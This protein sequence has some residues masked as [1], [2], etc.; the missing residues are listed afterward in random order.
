MKVFKVG[1]IVL[2]EKIDGEKWIFS[3]TEV[4]H[5]SKEEY[6]ANE[7]YNDTLGNYEP[8]K[9]KPT[10]SSVIITATN[11]S[12][13]FV[14]LRWSSGINKIFPHL[15]KKGWSKGLFVKLNIEL[16]KWVFPNA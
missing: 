8:E 4:F 5:L 14:E 2:K 13:D 9:E 16:S 6:T 11:Q 12:E 10:N 1:E 15:S 7:A 3:I